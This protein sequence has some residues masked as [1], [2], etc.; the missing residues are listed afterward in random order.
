MIGPDPPDGSLLTL[1]RLPVGYR[2][3][4]TAVLLCF[5]LGHAAGLLEQQLRAGLTP[6]G[7]AEWILGNEDDENAAPLLFARDGA[8]VLDEVWRRSL[9]DV[10]PTIVVLALLF[11]SERAPGLRRGAA[12][13]ITGLALLDLAGPALVFALGPPLGWVWWGA[14]C[15]L[16]A[17]VAG[18]AGL[19]V[20]EMWLRRA[21]G[22][23]FR[24]RVA[25]RA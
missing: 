3:L 12:L 17:A 20:A 19:C 25:A 11:R 21:R 4:Y 16:A 23:R 9:A 10:I 24:T 22:S 6:R 5:A 15:L 14:Q 18:A 2:I 8:E 13:G 1:S 7:A